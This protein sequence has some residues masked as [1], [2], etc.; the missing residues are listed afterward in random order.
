MPDAV[1]VRLFV[2]NDRDQLTELVNAH[3]AAVVPNLGVSVSGLLS[4]LEDE[5]SEFVVN[6]WV[7]ERVTLV[8]EQRKRVVAA[9]HLLRYADRDPVVSAYRGTGEI[10]WLVFWPDAPFWPDTSL[11]AQQLLENVL[12]RMQRWAVPVV[13]AD[14]ALPAP[15]VYGLPEQWPH[16][17]DLLSRNGFR[18]NGKVERIHLAR[19]A[20]LPRDVPEPAVQVT[21]RRTL[22][23]N[24]TRISAVDGDGTVHGYLE[25]ASL[26][27]HPRTQRTQRW[28]DLGNFE[29]PAERRGHGIERWLLARAADWLDLGG[30]TRLVAY[31]TDGEDELLETLHGNGFRLL[32]TTRRGWSLEASL[33]GTTAG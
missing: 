8:A 23:T 30:V 17:V 15:C 4:Q 16:V 31:S 29:A 3:V 12:A 26:D 5:P 19:V 22:G 13:R 32:T 7:A 9:A 1:T 21:A 24:G 18:H 11:A 2:R 10:A 33:A 25:V 28:A 20:D 14:G 6:P 27:C